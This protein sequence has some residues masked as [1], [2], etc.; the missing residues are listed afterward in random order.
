M[1]ESGAAATAENLRGGGLRRRGACRRGV[2]AEIRH[3]Q[4]DLSMEDLELAAQGGRHRHGTGLVGCGAKVGGV[5]GDHC[6]GGRAESAGRIISVVF[7]LRRRMFWGNT[8]SQWFFCHGRSG[9]GQKSHSCRSK[10]ERSLEI[11]GTSR[12]LGA[13]SQQYVGPLGYS[14]GEEG[15]AAGG[16]G[17]RRLGRIGRTAA[18]GD[19][20]KIGEGCGCDVRRSP[21]PALVVGWQ[22]ELTVW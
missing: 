20:E 6:S 4:Q 2:E 18:G 1:V 17:G 12:P 11:I 22:S 21:R 9:L 7:A 3:G 19:G 10:L 8:T 15:E 14:G 16:D 13:P 5:V